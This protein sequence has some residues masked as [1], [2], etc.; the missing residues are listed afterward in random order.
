M[1]IKVICTYKHIPL[2]FYF[3]ITLIHLF[4][5]AQRNYTVHACLCTLV[6][7]CNSCSSGQLCYI[8]PSAWPV[9]VLRGD[10]AP[11]FTDHQWF[12]VSLFNLLLI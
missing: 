6:H 10:L 4:V 9:G 8:S 5:L 2:H 11:S 12:K 7:M 1:G 3:F